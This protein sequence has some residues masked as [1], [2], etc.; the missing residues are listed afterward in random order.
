MATV[1][2]IYQLSFISGDAGAPKLRKA[3]SMEPD[4]DNDEDSNFASDVELPL[5]D[6]GEALVK[7]RQR[8]MSGGDNSRDDSTSAS[9]PFTR[10]S[11]FHS[12][13]RWR[14]V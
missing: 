13:K 12:S 14:Y 10:G 2:H 8:T 9:K 11:S 7:L 3:S 1:T 5:S 4:N 6:E